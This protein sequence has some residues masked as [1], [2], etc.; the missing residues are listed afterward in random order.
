ML[1]LFKGASGAQETFRLVEDLHQV[2]FWS[3]ELDSG[4]MQ[5]SHGFAK[6]LG[7]ARDT[8]PASFAELEA[9]IHPDDRGFRAELEQ[10]LREFIT[11]DREF[12]VVMASGRVRWV[13]IRAEAVTD[14]GR[15]ASRAVGIGH[16]VT[17]FHELAHLAQRSESRL[18]AFSRLSRALL[19]TA[20]ADGGVLQLQNWRQ[21]GWSEIDQ[22]WSDQLIPLVHGD[23]RAAF[24]ERWTQSLQ[25]GQPLSIEHRLRQPDS[26]FHWY[27]TRA[28]PILNRRG[29]VQEWVGI[30]RDLHDAD[31]LPLRRNAAHD[32]TGAQIRAARAI[33]G[34]SVQDLAEKVNVG[35]GVIR[36]LEEVDGHSPRHRAELASIESA[37]SAAGV[38]FTFAIGKKAGVRPR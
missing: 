6:L 37:L 11:I 23:D 28:M 29:V 14:I 10:M 8:G 9:A 25:G 30:S 7:L 38:E 19:W 15:S 4:A 31:E 2:G 18:Q 5:W 3:W 27:W 20:S 17:K 36:G 22:S 33:V 34:W 12:R 16:D 35:K 1:V 13:A 26:S 24:R 21:I 32:L